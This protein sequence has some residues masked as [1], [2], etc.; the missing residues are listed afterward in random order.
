MLTRTLYNILIATLLTTTIGFAQNEAN[1]WYFGQ[2]AGLDFN[3]GVPVPLLDGALNTQ[4]GCATISDGNGALLFYTDGITVYTKT[5]AVMQN[6]T[7]LNGDSSSTHSAIIV[8]KPNAPAIY[9]IFTVD[10]QA[11]SDGLQYSEVDLSLDGGLG[12]VTSN[13]NILLHTP[14]TE[15]LTAIKHQNANEYWVVSH[16]WDSSEFIAY[17]VS[18]M[19]VNTTPVISSTGT[20]VGGN[21]EF[22]AIG[23]VKISPDGTKLAVARAEGLS[24]VQLFDFDAGTGKL[25]NPLTLLDFSPDDKN[26]YGIE[27]S[28]NSKVLYISVIRQGVFQF[29]LEAG[30]ETAIINSKLEIDTQNDPY[31][32]MQLATDGKIYIAKEVKLY[33]DVIA[34]P[35]V[36][37]TGCTYQFESLYLGGRRCTSGLP[38]FIQSFLLINDIQFDNLC[39]GMGTHFSLTDAVDTAVWDFKDPASGVQNSS[40]SLTPTHLF[41]A[42]G[43]YEVSVTVTIG[44][45]TAS[46]TTTVT[47]YEQPLATPPKDLLICD[48]NNDG[49]YSFDLTA[50]NTEVFNG[51]S[52]ATF[53][54]HYY[55]SVADYTNNLPIP[56]PSS[57]TN[58][59][60][61][62]SQTLVA[63]L[64]NVQNADCADT[65]TFTIQVFESPTPSSNIPSLSFCDNSSVGTDTDGIILFDLT[66]NQSAILNGQ[67]PSN[68]S[69][70]YYTD[71]GFT[72][73]IPAPAAYQNTNATETIYVEVVNTANSNCVAQSSFSIAVFEL[74]TVT[75]LVELKQCDDN[76]DGFSVFNLS[77]VNAKLSANYLNETIHFYETETAAESGGATD[78][79]SNETAYTNQ[80]VST[81]TV[82]A[83]IENAKGCHRTSEVHLIISTTQIPA[84]FIKEFYQCDDGTNTNDGIATFDLS[85][86]NTEIQALFPV[87][88]QLLIKYYRNQAEALSELNPIADIVQ[89][90]NVGYP[91]T[92]TVFVRVDSALDNACLGLGHHITLYVETVPVANSISIAEQC[93][94]DGDGRFAFDTSN[95]ETTLLNGQTNVNV[96]YFDVAGLPFPSPLPNPFL[97]ASQ[98][99]TARVTNS[100][101]Q[102]ADGAC[103]DETPLVFTVDAAAVAHPL[104]DFIACDDDTDGLFSFDTS[105]IEAAVLNGQTGM[106][107]T[108][109]DSNGNALS[110]PLPNPF[111]STTQT[112]TVRVENQLSASCY[113]STTLNFVVSAQPTAHPIANHFVCDDVSN[114]GIHSFTLS[115][116]SSQILSGQSSLIFEVA[117][118]ESSTNAQNNTNPLPN[119]YDVNSTSKTVHARIQNKSNSACFDTTSFELGVHY[120]PIAHPPE[121]ILVCDDDSNDGV[122]KFDLSIQNTVILNGQPAT[123]H[124]LSYH[125]SLADAENDLNPQN[126]NFTNSVTPQTLFVRLENNRFTDC[127]TTTSFQLI[128]N[129]QPVLLMEQQWPICEGNSVRVSADAGYD[130]YLWSTGEMSSSILVNTPGTYEVTA[131]NRYGNLSCEVSKTITVVASNIATI[132]RVDT[133]DWTQDANKIV[134]F[135]EGNGAYEYSIDGINYQDSNEFTNLSIA[136]YV[137]SVRD[138]NGCGIATESVYLL[139]YPLFFTPNNDGYNDTWQL[140]NSKREPN[141]KIYIYDRYGKLLKQLNPSGNGWD[142]T[143][144]GQQLSSNDYWFV[145]ERQNGQTY[146]GH[147]TL[148]R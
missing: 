79:I 120:L 60:A 58:T 71:A 40:T 48:D 24:E 41:T 4:E 69:V 96:S 119:T 129:E 39:F 89:Y 114:D 140:L 86:V 38:P 54:I 92:Q 112:L 16:K 19:G 28:P 72:N 64:K 70:N 141:N 44:T 36:V 136:E 66:Q 33:I 108:Y 77:E 104:P 34:H 75:P 12:G 131:T 31:S 29:N 90:Q 87:G 101:S 97:T 55:A 115:D 17:N 43:T 135:V 65:T 56:N 57:Y 94:A 142:G 80:L 102:D 93:D 137:V 1:I 20:Y 14:T 26:V 78:L 68:F 145:L 118:F 67:L 74:P 51:Q 22:R 32:A 100:S 3:S 2:N 63:S 11:G 143:Y 95:I 127:F 132:V 25:S 139:Y 61:Y 126:T 88:Q 13:K 99:V 148:R 50:Q 52:T 53:E 130:E 111:V 84:S 125:L 9:Y 144:N 105:T 5:H 6:G 91:Q 42:S 35:N 81:D 123:E 27:F 37:G 103:F 49:F 113:D 62:A 23:Q 147:F 21:E 107:V 110:T 122:E 138:K 46:S 121:N 146:R 73:L 98:T 134:V 7:G 8:P 109:S 59:T 83:R 85:P 47:I 82:W 133:I 116:Y 10:F 45:Q 117:Y 128:V 106:N 30:S 18:D 76:L 124:T 15:K